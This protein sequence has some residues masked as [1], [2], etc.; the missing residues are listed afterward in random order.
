[1]WQGPAHLPLYSADAPGVPFAIDDVIAAV[2]TLHTNKSVAQPFLP[3]V[4]WRSA[5]YE[6]A[7]FIFQQL[8]QWWGQTPQ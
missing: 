3:G 5:P 4:V 1:M 8:N 6:V 7:H 2:S